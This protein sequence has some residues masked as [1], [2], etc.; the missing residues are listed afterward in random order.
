M[1]R[2]AA[3]GRLSGDSGEHE[4]PGYIGSACYYRVPQPGMGI[5]GSDQGRVGTRQQR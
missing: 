5:D 1:H 3:Q 4:F 2:D